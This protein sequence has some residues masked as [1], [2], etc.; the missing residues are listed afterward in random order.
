VIAPVQTLGREWRFVVAAGV[1]VA[2]SAYEAVGRR[3]GESAVPSEARELAEE[4]A[5]ALPAPDPV[6]V[7]DLVETSAGVRLLELNPFSG[8]DL[9]DCDRDRLVA[10]IVNAV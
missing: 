9:Y 1:V 7:L 4:I 3:A 8:A 2:C 5:A 10:A 6:F